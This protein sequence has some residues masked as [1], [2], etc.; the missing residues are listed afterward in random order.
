MKQKLI[1]GS[2]IVIGI[3]ALGFAGFKFSDYITGKVRF[4]YSTV[5]KVETTKSIPSSEIE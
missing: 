4:K 1:K 2:L 3:L 5:Q